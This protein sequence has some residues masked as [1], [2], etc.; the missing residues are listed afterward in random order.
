MEAGERECWTQDPTKCKF[1]QPWQL[2]DIFCV[3]WLDL[4][5]ACFVNFGN[6]LLRTMTG[7]TDGMLGKSLSKKLQLFENHWSDY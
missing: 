4:W 5:M 3:Q 1:C 7:F 6:Y 2:R